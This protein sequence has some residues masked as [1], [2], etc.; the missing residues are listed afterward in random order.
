M[1]IDRSL[2]TDLLLEALEPDAGETREWVVGD[3]EKPPEG[4]WQGEPG[5]S[6]WVPYVVLTSAPSDTPTGDFG[7]PGA[8]VW[9]RYGVTAVGRSRRGA[10]RASAAAR[11]QLESVPRQKTTDG[12]T[13]SQVQVSRY[14]GVERLPLEPPLFLVI[15]QVQVFTTK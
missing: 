2:L 1:S 7:T 3:H 13:V 15:D 12:R 10:E 9:F 4:G 14:G 11:G 6:Q 8:D 5:N